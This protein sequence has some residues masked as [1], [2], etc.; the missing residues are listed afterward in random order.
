[1]TLRYKHTKHI[2]S[3]DLHAYPGVF[4]NKSAIAQRLALIYIHSYKLHT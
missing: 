1:M 3:H 2:F 4:T